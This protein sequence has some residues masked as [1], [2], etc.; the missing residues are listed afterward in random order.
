MRGLAEG[1]SPIPEFDCAWDCFV[2]SFLPS[3][4]SEDDEPLAGLEAG[5]AKDT[6][7]L[8]GRSS[9][10]EGPVDRMKS[11]KSR[12]DSVWMRGSLARGLRPIGLFR[13]DLLGEAVGPLFRAAVR[14]GKCCEPKELSLSAFTRG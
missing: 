12:I 1:P 3:P 10:A 13:D 4:P 7:G 11:A 14:A 6:K 5:A 2:D 9:A 8:T